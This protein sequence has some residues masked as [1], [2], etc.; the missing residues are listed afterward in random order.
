MV[1]APHRLAR[2]LQVLQLVLADRDDRGLVEQDVRRHQHRVREEADEHVLL[3]AALLLELRHPGEV[4]QGRHV[5]QVP[6]ELGVLAHV[7]LDEQRA[8]LGI[9]AARDEIARHAVDARA[10]LRRLVLD[11]DG[12]GVHDAEEEVLLLLRDLGGPRA[13]GAE[14]VADVQL[15]ARLNAG[16]D[17]RSR[18]LG[19]GWVGSL[20][21]GVK[22]ME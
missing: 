12:V 19:H 10:E 5:G 20:S 16:E 13:H 4:P 22:L 1:E 3:A 2:E 21:Q 18:G 17:A 8:P 6:G 9:E 7:A 14:P 15:T 11:G